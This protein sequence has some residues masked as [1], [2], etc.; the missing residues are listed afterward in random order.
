MFI[1]SSLA[2]CVR[3]CAMFSGDARHVRESQ[4]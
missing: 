2:A 3:A 1:I 4:L